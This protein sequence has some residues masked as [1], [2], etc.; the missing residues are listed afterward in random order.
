MMLIKSVFQK[1]FLILP[2]LPHPV[3]TPVW[4]AYSEIVNFNLLII[5]NIIKPAYCSLGSDGR[6]AGYTVLEK[7]T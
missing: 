3:M 1:I 5:K 2:V 4:P 7:I 6:H